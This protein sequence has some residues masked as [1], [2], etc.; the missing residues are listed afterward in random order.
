MKKKFRLKER[1]KKKQIK[2][3][4]AKNRNKTYEKI[5]RKE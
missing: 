1:T 3:E 2:N 5:K 4:K